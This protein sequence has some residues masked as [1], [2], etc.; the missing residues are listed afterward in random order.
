MIQAC[1]TLL[2]GAL[3]CLISI[4]VVGIAWSQPAYPTKP[5]N[6]IIGFGTGGVT[7]VSARFL[8][9][10]A[11]KLLGQPF[12][13]S[14]NGGGGGSVAYELTKA[15]APDGYNLVCASSTGLVRIPQFRKVPYARDEFE[16][17]MHYAASYL[18]PIVV[19][20]SSPWKTFKELVDYAK[21]NPG[22][23]RY[24]TTGVGSPHHMAM[25]YVAKQEGIKWIHIPYPGSMPA[26]TALLGGHVEV[27]VGAGESIPYIKDGSLRILCHV[28][29]KRIEDWPQVPTLIDLGYDTYNENVF[30]FAA[31]KNTP[32]PIVDKLDDAFRQVMADPEFIKLLARIEL[33]PSYRG[34]AEIK[35]Y[36]D[37]A[38][39]RI[40]EMIRD[41][42][43]PK[44]DEQKK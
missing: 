31:P 2:A 6:V 17:I 43:L 33:Q 34:P 27:E 20:A 5:I 8:L 37:T 16:I 14:N 18:S 21:K 7:D 9:G 29:A 13:I 26:L 4:I 28:G 25:E 39:V 32:K 15:K 11:E 12:V 22:K 23:I 10:R 30:L 3:G 1:K 42:K 24:S 36:L 41:L 38:Y 19:K 44:E 40:G 35:K